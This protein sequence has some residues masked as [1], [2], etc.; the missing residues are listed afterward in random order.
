MR[1]PPSTL[2]VYATPAKKH[3][4]WNH[5]VQDFVG[6]LGRRSLNFFL[7]LLSLLASLFAGYLKKIYWRILMKFGG[8]RDLGLGCRNLLLSGGLDLG[9]LPV[10]IFRH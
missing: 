10:D 5:F 8:Q 7:P 6:I 9:F 1:F 2:F 3:C 4:L